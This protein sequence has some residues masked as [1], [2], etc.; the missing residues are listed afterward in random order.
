M[1]TF[2]GTPK[3]ANTSVYDFKGLSTDDK[4]TLEDFPNMENGSTFLEMD[5][6]HLSYWDAEHE[7]WV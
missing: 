2:T 1:I 5:T 7:E 3:T 6:K 4:P